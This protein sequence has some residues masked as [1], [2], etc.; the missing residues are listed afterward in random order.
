M[1]TSYRKSN[2]RL[3]LTM[4]L[5]SLLVTA[6]ATGVIFS[7]T[8]KNKK[9]YLKQ[10]SEHERGI[11]MTLYRQTGDADTLFTVL[12]D[13]QYLHPGLGKTGDFLLTR[14]KGDS[15]CF[16]HKQ[17]TDRSL[18]LLVLPAGSSHG[19]PG[20]LAAT[21]NTGYVKGPDYRGRNVLAYAEYLPDPGLG[22]VAKIDYSEIIKPFWRS[23]QVAIIS[24]LMLVLIG[25]Y[26]FRRFSAP[27][28][29]RI[30]EGEAKYRMIFEL[31]PSG[32]TIAGTTGR[33]LES[34]KESERLL[35][36][37]RE[38]H[39]SRNIDSEEWEIVRRDLSPMPASEYAST[40][41]LQEQRVITNVEMGIL[42]EKGR[43]T[44]LNVSAAPFPVQGMGVIVV[45]TDITR[46][47]EAEQRIR[48]HEN[49]L[50][51][52]AE[53]LKSLNDT[54][55]KFFGI[56]AHDL[57]N[58]FSSLLGATEY[59]YKEI[60]KH[61]RKKIR[62]LAKILYE[63]AQSGFDILTNL[64][65]WSRAQTGSLAY[66]PEEISLT[67]LVDKNI[68]LVAVLA[69]SKNIK[70]S[71]NLE[72]GL[73][74]TADENMLNT[75]LRNLLTNALK[76]THPGGAVKI[77]AGRTG[78]K[79]HVTVRDTGTGI[80]EK[81]LDKLFRIDVKYVNSGT[82]D[83]RGTGLGLLLC[84]EFINRHGGEIWVESR[85]NEGSAFHF[86]IPA[87]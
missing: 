50:E 59:L 71:A 3:L 56:I 24:S 35:G 66:D 32:I 21:G 73:T 1:L 34:N 82:N 80:P 11:L 67:G 83:E 39:A 12:R 45:Y 62:M 17:G 18:S 22:L 10:L 57:K 81:D 20:I 49:Q 75:V 27:L 61:D 70:I 63:S 33:I 74:L 26:F 28:F 86:T 41:A 78:S 30:R 87:G 76:F 51:M 7:Y 23:S 69:N 55:D 79:V 38:E 54:K 8:L 58:P 9:I 68:S 19:R 6:V 65:E 84:K 64:L 46:R 43:I 36:I 4:I 13:Q 85:L 48:D 53:E 77:E 72:P 29:N 40:R 5:V 44:W 47:V 37:P 60:E 2:F 25:I 42:K 14:M 15:V 52:Y 31:I 16:F